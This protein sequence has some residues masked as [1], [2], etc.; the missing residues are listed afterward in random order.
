MLTK[1]MISTGLR[2]YLQTVQGDR[3]RLFRGRVEWRPDVETAYPDRP[4]ALRSG[5]CFTVPLSQ[6]DTGP[7][8][9]RV[10]LIGSRR[11]LYNETQR[12]IDVPATVP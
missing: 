6:L 1:E 9:F 5:F 10:V 12:V 4:D 2:P 8:S 11:V 3:T 7:Q